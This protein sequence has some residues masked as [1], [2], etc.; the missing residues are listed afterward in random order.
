MNDRTSCTAILA[1]DGPAAGPLAALGGPAAVWLMFGIAL[2]LIGIVVLAA[3]RRRLVAATI[4]ALALGTGLAVQPAAPAVASVTYSDGCAL[5]DVGDLQI[6][7]AQAGEL[8][9]GDSG[10][11][12]RATVTN[13]TDLPLRL[14]ADVAVDPE[15]SL[16]GGLPGTLILGPATTDGP[17]HGLTGGPVSIG[18]GQAAAVNLTMHLDGLD[19]QF[20][21]LTATTRVTLTAI[22]ES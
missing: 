9:P 10:D 16:L 1:T 15:T 2:A 4:L 13:L 12:I 17:L 20:Q 8:L 19:D 5:I 3:R 18:P 7:T 11:L 22:Q 6:H 21:G 14:S